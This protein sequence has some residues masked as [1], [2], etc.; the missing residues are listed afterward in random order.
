[1]C[2]YTIQKL[3]LETSAV[4]PVSLKGMSPTTLWLVIIYRYLYRIS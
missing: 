4:A 2:K 1:M 3:G